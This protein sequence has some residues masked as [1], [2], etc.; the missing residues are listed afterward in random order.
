MDWIQLVT[1]Y[2]NVHIFL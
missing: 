1:Q 2:V